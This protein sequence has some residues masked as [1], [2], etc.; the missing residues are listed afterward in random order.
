MES[1]ESPRTPFNLLMCHFNNMPGLIIYDNSC[2]LHNFALKREPTRFKNT[3]FMIDRLH[4]RNHKCTRGYSMDSY[5]SDDKIK[6]TN[7]QANEQVNSLLRRLST[8]VG[9]MSSDNAKHHVSVFLA[10]RNIDINVNYA[11]N[12]PVDE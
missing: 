2:H 11:N 9:G 3:R 8:P 12:K 4:Y 6:N 10:L 1:A 7:S 5:V